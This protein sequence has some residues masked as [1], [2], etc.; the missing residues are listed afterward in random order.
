MADGKQV[1]TR[2]MEYSDLL[3]N[4][5]STYHQM[6]EFEKTDSVLQIVRASNYVPQEYWELKYD[7]LKR[8][9]QSEAALDFL[10]NQIQPNPML[11]AI[12]QIEDYIEQGNPE[13]AEEELD[14]QLKQLKTKYP[15]MASELDNRFNFYRFQVCRSDADL[16]KLLKHNAGKDLNSDYLNIL[17]TAATKAYSL[18][19]RSLADSLSLKLMEASEKLFGRRNAYRA[20]G[21]S[22]LLQSAMNAGDVIKARNYATDLASS[23]KELYGE[24]SALYLRGMYDVLQWERLLGQHEKVNSFLMSGLRYLAKETGK[25][26]PAYTTFAALFY[27]LNPGVPEA[28]RYLQEAADQYNENDDNCNGCYA[29]VISRLAESYEKAGNP[30]KAE[31]YFR[32]A[33]EKSKADQESEQFY[34]IQLTDFYRRCHSRNLRSKLAYF[35]EEVRV[36]RNDSIRLT[37][38]NWNADMWWLSDLIKNYDAALTSAT[39]T[40]RSDILYQKAKLAWTENDESNST[41][42]FERVTTEILQGLNV[43]D[44]M[45]ESEKAAYYKTVSEPIQA[46]YAFSTLLYT[47]SDSFIMQETYSGYMKERIETDSTSYIIRKTTLGGQPYNE[48]T[49]LHA[50][51]AFNLR[52][53]SKGMVFSSTRKVREK[54]LKNGDSELISAYTRLEQMKKELSAA[55]MAAS[56]PQQEK[57]RSVLAQQIEALELQLVE[58]SAAL[59]SVRETRSVRFEDV[60]SKLKPGEAAIEV[61]RINHPMY[62][63]SDNLTH[64]DS[65]YY[66]F[67][68]ITPENKI[69]PEVFLIKNGYQL[70]SRFYKAYKNHIAAQTED[71]TSFDAFWKPVQ[72]Q[73]RG[74]TRIYFSSDGIYNLININTLKNPASGKYLLE[75]LEIT[76]VPDLSAVTETAFDTGSKKTAVIFG[77]PQFA[78]TPPHGDR[79]SAAVSRSF[80]LASI[81]EDDIPP[82]T[83]TESEVETIQQLLRRNQWNTK[84]FKGQNASEK[85][86][87]QMDSPS[88]VHVATHGFFSPQDG[89]SENPLMRSGLIMAGIQPIS[90]A[91]EEDGILTAFEAQSINLSETELV[92]LSACET[93]TGEISSGDGVYGLQRAF[94]TAG[95]RN[96]I[97][98]LW[99]VDD[100]ATSL[101][102]ETFYKEWT[103]GLSKN[104]AL[105]KAELEVM[106]TYPSP[107]YWGAFVLLGK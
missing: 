67:L 61:I 104:A 97:M 82:L 21:S 31:T 79:R 45:T 58:K 35:P 85:N 107:Y 42:A 32:L 12:T 47:I 13:A 76:L 29:L 30:E 17:E 103:T 98:S 44:H 86:F 100:A 20:N 70:E 48:Y 11:Y 92:V 8:T 71:R 52:L 93:G 4:F 50:K 95:S 56:S 39:G 73:L 62:Y 80:S 22:A 6:N 36:N 2:K 106:K 102:M 10:E 19:N 74:K 84:L 69:K 57:N 94:L 64:Q 53:A 96:I 49:R 101:L 105:R 72:H 41:L 75:E 9:G 63:L 83:A 60:Q 68:L 99:A 91:K 28:G 43:L 89:Y 46:F 3:I 66:A 81:L 33:W 87:K 88:L 18:N 14:L 55:Y 34:R 65:I 40:T 25:K 16:R 23:L 37:Y 78:E 51:K 77:N 38:R 59:K 54:I 90:A 24:K 5:A 26:H 15:K 27:T 7:M 1:K